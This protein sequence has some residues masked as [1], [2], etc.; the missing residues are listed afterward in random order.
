[1]EAGRGPISPPRCPF[2]GSEFPRTR[3]G[4]I[5]ALSEFD[6]GVCSCGAIFGCDPVGNRLGALVMDMLLFACDGDLDLALS[7]RQGIDYEEA[8]LYGYVERLHHLIPNTPGPR[9]G[10]GTILVLR[11]LG[12]HG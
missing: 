11:L 1:M 4:G 2:C 5:G 6:G 12:S 8:W 7:L 9:R 3:P 10:V